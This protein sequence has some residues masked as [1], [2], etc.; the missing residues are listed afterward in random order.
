MMGVWLCEGGKMGL[1][2]GG[3]KGR[4]IGIRDQSSNPPTGVGCL[5]RSL[6]PT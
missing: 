6:P 2:E 4:G 3:G 1:G 5:P